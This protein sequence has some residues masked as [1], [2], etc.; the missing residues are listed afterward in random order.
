MEL[1]AMNVRLASAP[2]SSWLG[3]QVTGFDGSTL[4]LEVPWRTEFVGTPGTQIAHGGVLAAVVDTAGSYVV[5]ASL[6]KPVPTIDL[7]IDYHRPVVDE[8]MA[9]EARLIR[10]GRSLATA[11]VLVYTPGDKVAVSARGLYSV[12]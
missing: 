10:L 4:T 6:G 2:Y 8:A 1:A 12:V 9:V 7:R 5:A 11:E 3:I